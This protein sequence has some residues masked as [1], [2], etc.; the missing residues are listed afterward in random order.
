MTFN[1]TA[2]LFEQLR[3]KKNTLNVI[4]GLTSQIQ[5]PLPSFTDVIYPQAHA[6]RLT[7]IIKVEQSVLN[8]VP[9]HFKKLR[10]CCEIPHSWW[11]LINFF[12]TTTDLGTKLL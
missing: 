12:S 2:Y 10:A 3:I 9:S 1:Y 8:P 5:I 4:H 7:W 11:C 6:S